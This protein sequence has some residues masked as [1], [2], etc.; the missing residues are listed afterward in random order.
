MGEINPEWQG[1]RE[2][3]GKGKVRVRMPKRNLLL[4]LVGFSW[5]GSEHRGTPFTPIV[6]DE[7]P[8]NAS[9]QA[10]NGRLSAMTVCRI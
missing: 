3:K 10:T 4:S 6:I 2:T 1:M 9:E 8:G 5:S 7:I